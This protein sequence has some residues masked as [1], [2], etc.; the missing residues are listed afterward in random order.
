MAILA[1]TSDGR[2]PLVRQYRPAIE[3]FT[4]ELPAGLID[5]DEP[6]GETCRRELREETGYVAGRLHA[7][8]KAVVEAGRLGNSLHGFFVE[9][10]GRDEAHVPEAGVETAL[11]TASDFREWIVS[12]RFPMQIHVGVVLQAIL[13]GYLKP[14]LGRP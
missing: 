11:V 14:D 13:R 9:I 1:I 4:W 12:G 2:F 6:P 7:L 10:D 8:G 3:A 5:G